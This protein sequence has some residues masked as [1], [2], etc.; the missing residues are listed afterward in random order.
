[1]RRSFLGVWALLACGCGGTDFTIPD[2]GDSGPDP[3]M[4]G[5]GGDGGGMDAC[6]SQPEVCGDGIDNDCDGVV[7]NGCKS[8]GTYVSGATGV[9]TNP[10]TKV[11]P[12]K[13]IAQ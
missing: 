8:L 5:G 11:S 9:D 7:D 12:V 2:A 6:M 13:T 1:M 10:G 3:M 4:E